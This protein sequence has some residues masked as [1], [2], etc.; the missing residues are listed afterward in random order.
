VQLNKKRQ[1]RL[2]YKCSACLIQFSL[3]LFVLHSLYGR[4]IE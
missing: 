3:V 4:P 2:H 1:Q